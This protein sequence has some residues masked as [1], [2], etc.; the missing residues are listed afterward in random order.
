[1]REVLE[2]EPVSGSLRQAACDAEPEPTGEAAGSLPTTLLG[3]VT[4]TRRELA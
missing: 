3:N 2:A 1:M 4:F